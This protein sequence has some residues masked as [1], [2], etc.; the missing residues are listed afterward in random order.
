MTLKRM[1]GVEKMY[2]QLIFL[3]RPYSS[4]L[5]IASPPM[6]PADRQFSSPVEVDVD[7]GIVLELNEIHDRSDYQPSAN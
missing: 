3:I 6:L 5:S 2:V 7:V 4:P 1:M